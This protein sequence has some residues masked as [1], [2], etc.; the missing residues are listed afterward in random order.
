MAR[1]HIRP[2][3]TLHLVHPVPTETAGP[4]TL[5]ALHGEWF[6]KMRMVCYL[7]S[8]GG[9]FQYRFGCTESALLRI[10]CE[11]VIKCFTC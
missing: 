4:K 1:G 3:P 6:L 5:L 9:P 11:L 8:G 7:M 10:R 2:R